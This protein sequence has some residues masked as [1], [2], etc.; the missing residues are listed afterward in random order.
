MSRFCLLNEASL[1][2]TRLAAVNTRTTGL[3]PRIGTVKLSS[4]A[5]FS[6]PAAGD[7][8]LIPSLRFTGILPQNGQILLNLT[9]PWRGL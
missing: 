6:L 4:L 2:L 3:K 5:A 8:S 1:F 9:V 7:K